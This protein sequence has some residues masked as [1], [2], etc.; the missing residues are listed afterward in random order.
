M[1]SIKARKVRLRLSAILLSMKQTRKWIPLIFLV[2]TALGCNAF[3]GASTP[4]PA[5]TLSA[6]ATTSTK[7][8]DDGAPTATLAA[9]PTQ[10]NIITPASADVCPSPGTATLPTAPPTF[11]DYATT[12]EAFLSGGGSISDLQST[13]GSWG[14]I[15]DQAGGVVSGQDLT[16]DGAPDVVVA[17]QAPL[18][19]FPDTA[20]GPPGDLYIYGC[21]GGAYELLFGDYST[22]DRVTPD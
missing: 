22:P 21:V 19:Q 11:A 2:I 5:I 1:R 9:T 15:T 8:T 14:G 6:A 13:L 7:A 4:T 12:I 3:S 20:I 16:G 17:V 10:L 18:E